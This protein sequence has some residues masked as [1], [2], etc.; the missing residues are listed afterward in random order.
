MESNSTIYATDYESY[1]VISNCDKEFSENKIQFNQHITL[2]SRTRDIDD[3]F[4]D[5]VS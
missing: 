2:W 1:A 3:A 4:V 5:R